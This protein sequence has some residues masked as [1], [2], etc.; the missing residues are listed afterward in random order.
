MTQIATFYPHN[1][2]D[3]DQVIEGYFEDLH[4]LSLDQ[5]R[6]VF[7]LARRRLK[8]FPTIAELLQIAAESFAEPALL[9]PRNQALEAWNALR[10]LTGS[11][12]YTPEALED[13]ITYHCFQAMGGEAS[14]GLWDYDRDEARM[15]QYFCDLYQTYLLR[16]AQHV[17]H[18]EA[19]RVLKDLGYD[20][21]FRGHWLGAGDDDDDLTPRD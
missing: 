18:D 13:P 7:V 21:T 20:H 12:A 6:A 3:I 11:K 2:P 15:R 4:D 19:E 5:V 9:P 17:S 14:F 8:F 16:G 1:K 10:R